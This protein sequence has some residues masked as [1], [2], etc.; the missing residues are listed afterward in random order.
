MQPV[1][2][3]LLLVHSWRS[4]RKISVVK[5][6]QPPQACRIASLLLKN[7]QCPLT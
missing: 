7:P 4:M 1:L 5:L 6:T 3:L 2:L